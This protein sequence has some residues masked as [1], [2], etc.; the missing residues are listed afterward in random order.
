M[1]E[2]RVFGHRPLGSALNAKKEISRI[3]EKPLERLSKTISRIGL[4]SEVRRYQQ[5]YELYRLAME[6]GIEQVS[7]TVR[8]RKGPYYVWRVGGRY[9]KRQRR[10]A[11]KYKRHRRYLELDVLTCLIQARIL[12]D[13]AV[14]LSRAFLQGGGNLPG[15]TSFSAQKKFFMKLQSPY[16]IHQEYAERIRDTSWFDV[17]VKS[18]RD[19]LVVHAGPSH[20]R[21]FGIPWYGKGDDLEMDFF[22]EDIGDLV[23]AESGM[24]V[25]RLNVLRLAHDIRGFLHWFNRYGL[26]ALGKT[27]DKRLHPT[28]IRAN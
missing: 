24:G 8:W 25:V 28:A 1:S 12:L 7:S 5:A 10:V 15:F 14:G 27:P 9:G 21:S 19:K 6:R 2:G 26:K 18:V 16:G 3:R 22:L 23:P 13:R 20:W 11:D 4:G 17:P